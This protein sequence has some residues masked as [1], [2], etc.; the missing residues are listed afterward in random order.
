MTLLLV[1]MTT[2]Y[3]QPLDLLGLIIGLQIAS[4][5]P[6]PSTFSLVKPILSLTFIWYYYLIASYHGNGHLNFCHPLRY[7]GPQGIIYILK[8]FQ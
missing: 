1:T 4:N 2:D 7:E 3:S 6:L 5:T 8:F